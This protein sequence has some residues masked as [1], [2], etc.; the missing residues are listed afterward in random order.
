MRIIFVLLCMLL[1]LTGCDNGTANRDLFSLKVTD[2]AGMPVSGLEVRIKNSFS[3]GIYYTRPETCITFELDETSHVSLDIFNLYNQEVKCLIDDT[4]EAGCHA[5]VLHLDQNDPI[6]AGGTNIFKYTLT[7][8][9]PEDSTD[10]FFQDSK[11]MCMD[12]SLD[13]EL[14][15]IGVIDSLGLFIFDNLCAFPH[16]FNDGLGEQPLYDENG[17]YMGSFTLSDS[18]EIM[19]INPLT[20]EFMDFTVLM[21][22]SNHNHYDLVWHDPQ[23]LRSDVTALEKQPVK[24]LRDADDNDVPGEYWLGQ[25]YP[26]PFY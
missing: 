15:R 2:A 7:S 3:D 26:N 19:L 6:N 8:T 22:N 4:L 21:D 13:S 23:I 9:N 16:L 25:N 5:V 10:V 18:I 24:S 1:M 14:S 17:S 11:Y 20:D 12:V